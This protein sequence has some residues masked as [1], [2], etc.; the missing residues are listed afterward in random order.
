MKADTACWCRLC[1]P[2]TVLERTPD[3]RHTVHP[4]WIHQSRFELI[5]PLWHMYATWWRRADFRTSEAESHCLAMLPF[6][7]GTYL[8]LDQMAFTWQAQNRTHC[9]FASAHVLAETNAVVQEM[10]STGHVSA[11]LDSCQG[12]SESLTLFVLPIPR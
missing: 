1:N 11:S 9:I 5:S 3:I 7:S 12:R 10:M 2:G 6:P 8:L 4:H